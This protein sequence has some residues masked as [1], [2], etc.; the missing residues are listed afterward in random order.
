VNGLVVE[1]GDAD[2]L[3]GAIERF[4]GEDG[5]AARLREH[6]SSSVVDYAPDRV[7]ARLERI[8]VAALG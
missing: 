2:A 8:L 1:P 5:L 7:Y 6:A 3:A 4:F